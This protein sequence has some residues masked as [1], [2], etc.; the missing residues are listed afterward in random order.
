[1]RKAATEV[2]SYF[3]GYREG[4]HIVGKLLQRLHDVAKAATEVDGYYRGCHIGFNADNKAAIKAAV[5]K[6]TTEFAGSCGGCC[7]EALWLMQRL[8]H[9][10]KADVKAAI[11]VAGFYRGCN[12]AKKAATL[13]KRLYRAYGLDILHKTNPNRGSYEG[14]KTFLSKQA[15]T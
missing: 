5:V 7:N 13:L 10:L 11:K 1:M 8:L 9:R 15:I 14:Y 4:C 2:A 6:A 3:E 12:I